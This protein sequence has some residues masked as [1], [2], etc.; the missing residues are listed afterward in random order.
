MPVQFF[1]A[2]QM[3]RYAGLQAVHGAASTVQ[4]Y[5][6]GG[7]LKKSWSTP[8]YLPGMGD[9]LKKGD[10]PKPPAGEFLLHLFSAVEDK[11]HQASTSTIVSSML[12]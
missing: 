1:V 9:F 4:L 11:M 12:D 2:A 7:V 3:S 10:T 5:R 8:C 6:I